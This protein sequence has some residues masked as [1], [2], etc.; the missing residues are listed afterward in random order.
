MPLLITQAAVMPQKLNNQV[1]DQE[2]HMF[3]GKNNRL[4][5]SFS[6]RIA[7]TVVVFALWSGAGYAL[8][9]LL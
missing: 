8:L 6:F 9:S 1:G 2:L 3:D 5:D 7:L 4:L